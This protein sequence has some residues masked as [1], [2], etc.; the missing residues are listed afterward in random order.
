M[1]AL[2][3]FLASKKAIGLTIAEVNPDHDPGLRMTRRLVDEVVLGLKTR[4]E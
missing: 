2:K 1:T 3:I 4:L